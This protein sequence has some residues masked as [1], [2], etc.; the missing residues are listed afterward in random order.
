[1]EEGAE[2]S[3]I[4]GSPLW[5]QGQPDEFQALWQEMKAALRAAKQDWEVWTNWYDDRL[6]GRVWDEEREPAYVR[7]KEALW[8][9]GPAIV[10]AE[11]KR[12]AEGR[13]RPA[14]VENVPS[15]VSFSWSSRG[16]IT[17]VSGALNWP[18]FPF[19]DAEKDHKNRP[20]RTVGRETQSAS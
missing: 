2:S 16:T 10:N 6:A 5:P 12:R 11:I 8:D 18:V 4:A 15:A 7:I 3:D 13:G 1:V 17:V 14:P 20:S 9:Q 19:K